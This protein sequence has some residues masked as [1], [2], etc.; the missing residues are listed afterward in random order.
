MGSE[1]TAKDQFI[2]HL[3][4][5]RHEAGKPSLGWLEQLSGHKFVKTT[6]D[7]HLSGRRT[8]LPPWQLVAAYVDACHRAADAT[9]LDARKL[10]SLEEWHHRYG[11]ALAGDS[12]APCPVRQSP[13]PEEKQK[14]QL[15]VDDSP[16]SVI[17]PPIAIT[18]SSCGEKNLFT[19][20]FCMRCRTPISGNYNTSSLPGTDDLFPGSTES[21]AD[22]ILIA[23]GLPRESAVLFVSRGQ[24]AGQCF[25]VSEDVTTI[26]RGAW[27]DVFLDDT[28][29]SR[30][31]SIISR[32]GV[33][34]TI[35]DLGSSNGTFVNQ[36]SVKSGPLR[37]GDVVHIGV[38]RLVFLQGGSVD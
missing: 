33:Y 18:C 4:V 15:E 27:N 17:S 35:R 21:R 34:F 23:R 7:D 26:G 38:I 37:S 5:L 19:A 3:N 31:H 20:K 22:P 28:S 12:K 25:V 32:H 10:G 29:V 1:H 8:G 6:L 11:A 36:Q 24:G 30:R 16:T 2:E 9:G 14:F 13:I